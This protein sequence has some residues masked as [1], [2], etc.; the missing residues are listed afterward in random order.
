[1]S[2]INETRVVDSLMIRVCN[3]PSYTRNKLKDDFVE[4]AIVVNYKWATMVC[5]VNLLSEPKAMQSFAEQLI[6]T[7]SKVKT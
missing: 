3:D 5:P 2:Y 6:Y 1:M 7:L 4:L